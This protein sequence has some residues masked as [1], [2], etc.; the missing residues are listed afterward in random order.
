MERLNHIRSRESLWAKRPAATKTAGDCDQ[1]IGMAA[2]WRVWRFAALEVEIAFDQWRS[3]PDGGDDREYA[4]YVDSLRREADAAH[5][6]AER[7]AGA[8]SISA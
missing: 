7:Y 6:L 3:A 8:S 2:L 1:S 4:I 5:R